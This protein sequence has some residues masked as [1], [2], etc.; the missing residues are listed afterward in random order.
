MKSR[1][2]LIFAL[3]LTLTSF[4]S[5][6]KAVKQSDSKILKSAYNNPVPPSIIQKLEG[7]TVKEGQSAI[8]VVR[9]N[10]SPQCTVQW[11]KDGREIQPKEGSN[12]EVHVSDN[13]AT[14]TIHRVYLEDS[15]RYSV[16]VTNQL[17]FVESSAT[18]KVESS[19]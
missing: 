10:G 14:F 9:F 12:F 18:L 16:K 6:E 1:I 13:E 17:G 2:I 19:K 5:D 15:G 11:F 8:F 3:F 4:R 7:F